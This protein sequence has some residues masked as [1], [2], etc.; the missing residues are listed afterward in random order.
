M[1]EIN[2]PRIKQPIFERWDL[3]ELI[4]KGRYGTVYK[5]K[6]L[7]T[8]EIV[9]VK[10]MS[11]P[12]EEMENY[13]RSEYGNNE[14]D[15]ANFVGEVAENFG[16]EIESMKKLS[17]VPYIV[18]LYDN[19]LIQKGIN[20]D[21]IMVMEYAIPMKKY[22]LDKDLTVRDVLRIGS[23]I[24]CGLMECEQKNIIHRDIKEDNLFIGIN[25]HIGKMG[26]FGVSSINHTGLAS[27]VGMGTPYYMAPE[28]KR[29]EHYDGRVDIYSLGIVL[30]KMLNGNRFP[31]ESGLTAKDALTQR[32]NGAEIPL[33]SY[34]QNIL[35][36]VVR[37][38][39]NY[40]P[41]M[42]YHSARDLYIAFREVENTLTP[43]EL[44]RVL[45]YVNGTK[46]APGPNSVPPTPRPN[47]TPN[48][49]PN[50]TPPPQPA[51]S[52]LD[53]TVDVLHNIMNNEGRNST[54][55]IVFN[56][57]LQAVTRK[58]SDKAK[59]EYKKR[60]K[61][62][63]V[64]V[65]FILFLTLIASLIL[66]YPKAVHF[67]EEKGHLYVQHYPFLPP[68][69]VFD[70]FTISY[71]DWNDEY[72]YFTIKEMGDEDDEE[73]IKENHGDIYRMPILPWKTNK[74]KMEKFIDT[75]K[76]NE[77]E[78]I[79]IVGD[80][81]CYTYDWGETEEHLK[82]Y[83]KHK[84]NLTKPYCLI[85][86][87]CENLKKEDNILKCYVKELEFNNTEE[88]EFSEESIKLIIKRK[89]KSNKEKK[90]E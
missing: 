6:D 35:G 57:L 88:Q 73:T 80:Y 45:P 46:P 11:L 3:I 67:T 4:G 64:I 72:V 17:S 8:G 39:C 87:R 69:Q 47:P 36:E 81:I 7:Q 49:Q 18:K 44:D 30:Y 27:T 53:K 83:T 13:A 59:W 41:D 33:P 9:A 85:D 19:R 65:V 61:R 38:C 78:H 16:N 25:D 55:A 70:E 58:T 77:C 5:A 32:Q 79:F 76:E 28:V 89:N 22:F 10:I 62:N 40:N 63:T 31:L 20:H 14:N 82:L 90:G 50:P 21:I 56:G 34:C 66:L 48:P 71:F 26:D 68:K 54:V 2:N 1:L 51:Q 42:R 24:A 84:D 75:D 74:S 12:N 86:S 37:K 23:H 60:R 29:G 52:F 43:P 15:I